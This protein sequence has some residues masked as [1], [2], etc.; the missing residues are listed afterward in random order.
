MFSRSCALIVRVRTRR[1]TKRDETKY[2]IRISKIDLPLTL[3]KSGRFKVGPQGLEP[4][5]NGL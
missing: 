5:T 2:F 1:Q 4:R 3:Y